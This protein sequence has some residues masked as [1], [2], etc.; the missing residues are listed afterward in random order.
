MP[1]QAHRDTS[2][3]TPKK[4][5]SKSRK[6]VAKN[7]SIEACLAKLMELSCDFKMRIDDYDKRI[8]ELEKLYCM[9][10]DELTEQSDVAEE[11]NPEP[12]TAS[13]TN[14]EPETE[15]SSGK[16]CNRVAKSGP[17]YAFRYWDYKNK[18]YGLT[19]DIWKAKQK[20]SYA[21]IWVWYDDGQIDHI[22]SNDELDEYVP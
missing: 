17:G 16:P 18:S 22:L 8:K 10:R 20:G 13:K 19:S 9:E 5:D 6:P 15:E 1:K 12:E 11:T 21:P 4:D 2:K 14:P 7:E 3:H